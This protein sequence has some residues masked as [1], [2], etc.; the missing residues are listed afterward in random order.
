MGDVTDTLARSLADEQA[1]TGLLL[2]ALRRV[3]VGVTIYKPLDDG[4]DYLHVFVNPAYQALK[5]FRPI[6]GRLY[7]EVWP[8]LVDYAVPLLKRVLATG[9]TWMAQSQPLEVEVSEGVFETRYFT[10]EIQRIQMGSDSYLLN[11]ST[12]VTREVAAADLLAQE[13]GR[14]KEANDALKRAEE[15]W[16]LAIEQLAEG[17]I[18]ATEDEQIIYWNPA[19]RRMHGFTSPEEGIEPLEE[20]RATFDLVTLEEGRLLTLDEWPMKRIKSG[21]RV[22]DLVLRL[23]RSDQGWEKIVSYSGSMLDTPSGERLIFLSVHDLTEERRAQAA[24]ASELRL[25]SSLLAAARALSSSIEPAKTLAT[26]IDVITEVSGR[27]RVVISRYEERYDEFVIEATSGDSPLPVGARIRVDDLAPQVRESLQQ[28]R[29]IVVD[30]EEPGMPQQ[31]RD[32]ARKLSAELSLTVPLVVGDRVVGHIGMDEPGVRREFSKRDIELIEGIASQAAVAIENA[33]TFDMEHRVADQLQEALLALPDQVRGV[34]FAGAY[35]SAAE[36]A[37]VG[38]DFY[39]LFELGEDRVGVVI[40]DVAGKG[41][42]ASVLTS[43]VRNTVRA[44]AYEPEKT[45]ARI[46]ELTN[47]IVYSATPREAF[48]TLFFGVLDRRDGKMV[49]ANAGH[50]TA[51]IVCLDSSASQLPVTGPLLG[52][53]SSARFEQAESTLGFGEILFLYTDGLTEA[54]RDSELYGEERVFDFLKARHG[55]SPRDLVA[56]IV[57]DVVEFSGQQLRDDL[58]ILAVKRVE[59]GTDPPEQHVLELQ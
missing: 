28:R 29:P 13:R 45:P 8:E 14:L 26:L 3:G 30:Y 57:A 51:A 40:G 7:S 16:S 37:R 19:A 1:A 52:A 36:A 50:T 21:Q 31:S 43:M 22:R 27:S 38:G 55:G 12:E 42:D 56:D 48:V 33:R 10:F 2:E 4:D 24:A 46:L 17:A 34:E 44:H 23:R 11:I 59:R 9:E 20:T 58:A 18:I 5:P 25:T 6:A 35:H 47:E 53:F 54:R 39:D 49:Y 15:R 32:R 41:L